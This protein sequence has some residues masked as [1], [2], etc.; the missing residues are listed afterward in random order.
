MAKKIENKNVHT[1]WLVLVELGGLII[2]EP[3][4][5]ERFP[6]GFKVSPEKV[7]FIKN[8]YQKFELSDD[9]G[10]SVIFNDFIF[11]RILGYELYKT[12]NI[13]DYC[14]CYLPEYVQDLKPHRVAESGNERLLIYISRKD[15]NLKRNE[16]IEGKWKASPLAKMQRLLNETKNHFGL[17]SNGEEFILVYRPD[18]GGICTLGFNARFML[19]EPAVL[20]AFLGILDKECLS[21]LLKLARESYQKQIEVTDTLGEQVRNSVDKFIRIFDRCDQ[22]SKYSLLAEFKPEKVYEMSISA[23]MKLIFLLYAEEHGLLPY[24]DMLYDNSYSVHTLVKEL[25]H[26]KFENLKMFE[27]NTSAWQRI[28]A[29]FNLIYYGSEHNDLKSPEYSGELFDPEKFPP[30]YSNKFNPTNFEIYNCLKLLTH[31]TAKV[32]DETISQAFSY[33]TLGV[34]HIGYIYEGLLDFTIKRAKDETLVKL[35]PKNNETVVNLDKLINLTGDALI[36]FIVETSAKKL[37]AARVKKL[38]DEYSNYAENLKQRHDIPDDI[39]EIIYKYSPVIQLDKIILPNSLYLT[40]SDKR[41]ATGAH[42]TPQALTEKIVRTTLDPLVYVLEKDEKGNELIGKIA[43]PKVLRTPNEL[44]NLKICDPAMGSGAFLVQAIRYMSDKLVE[45]WHKIS[46]N[47]N[48]PIT[49]PLGAKSTGN[50]EER[51]LPAEYNEQYKYAKRYVAMECIYGVDINPL[52]VEIAKL[53]IWLETLAKDLPF[54]FIDHKLLCGDSL[55]GI[56]NIDD[57]EKV[58]QIGIYDLFSSCDAKKIG[59]AIDARLEIETMPDFSVKDR[60]I[61]VEKLKR[62][63]EELK[64]VKSHL[65]KLFKDHAL[66]KIYSKSKVKLNGDPIEFDNSFHWLLNFS[67]VFVS[68]DKHKAGFDAIIGNPP[69]LGGQK[70]TGFFGE[71]YREYLVEML[72]NQ[73]RGSAD[74][75]AYFFLRAVNLLKNSGNFGLLATNTIAQG[76]TR[77]T[78]LSQVVKNS[79]IFAAF[80]DEPWEGNATVTTSRVHICKT[81][82]WFGPKILWENSVEMISPFLSAE[83]DRKPFVLKANENRS[84]IGSYVLGMG[85]TLSEEEALEFIKKDPKNKDVLY[86]YLN[87]QDLNSSPTLSPSRWVINFW[88]WP[89]ERARQYSDL[90]KIVEEKVKPER[91]SKNDKIAKERWWNFLRIRVELYHS[92]GRH[93]FFYNSQNYDGHPK[94][95]IKKILLKTLTSKYMTFCFYPNDQII[96]QTNIV[97]AYYRNFYFSLLQSNFHVIWS[98]KNGAT[99]ETR[100]RYTP[101]DCFETFPFPNILPADPEK[102]DEKNLT[103]KKLDALGEEYHTLRKNM[104]LNFN[105]GLTNL[106]NAF[107]SPEEKR[108]EFVKLRSLHKQIDE[109]VLE[110]YG[111]TDIKLSHDFIEVTYLPANDRLRYTICEKARLELLRR[112]LKLNFER[113]DEEAKELG[114]EPTSD[115]KIKKTTTKKASSHPKMP[116][117]GPV[118]EGQG[119]L[120]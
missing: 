65:T 21:I 63:N 79:K 112:L 84:F 35:I 39:K 99:L 42:Y 116:K 94:E 72:A 27:S 64:D 76:D 91:E 92:I 114:L 45:T 41:R 87:G 73:M 107:H 24:G 31:T 82:K 30:L 19:D 50:P 46:E 80:P 52:A 22:E 9:D 34:E 117:N 77:E 57:L 120:F 60:K 69:F 59:H 108:D 68:V 29:L 15:Q 26:E 83:D 113:H 61:K 55:L 33:K 105:I 1:D 25:E 47:T 88:D 67:E 12:N 66:D 18:E 75:V 115:K 78:G 36:D 97:F 96:D 49:I 95:P 100:P 118:P 119:E 13:P 71:E 3:V 74:L 104:M 102:V 111:W 86:P 81:D 2:S 98:F 109:T 101:S 53:S 23:V 56:T 5:L 70:L 48:D 17:V 85:F 89:I 40:V 7:K 58:T 11:E 6:G 8:Y 90:F 28:L 103:V 106:Y 20:A 32:G 54:T 93:A 51:L 4:L 110:A 44:L 37:T 14:A 62:S 16:S 10:A 38:L 43:E